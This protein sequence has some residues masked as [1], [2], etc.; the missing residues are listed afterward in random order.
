M[1]DT[2]S[3]DN[4]HATGEPVGEA[5]TDNIHA[6]SE[7][8]TTKNLITKDDGTGDATPD[9]IHATDEPVEFYLGRTHT[10]RDRPRRRGGGAVAAD[11]C[12]GPDA[13]GEGPRRPHGTPAA[14][15]ARHHTAQRGRR[16]PSGAS[17]YRSRHRLAEMERDKDEAI[18][19]AAATDRLGSLSSSSDAGR[20]GGDRGSRRLDDRAPPSTRG[21]PTGT[22]PSACRHGRDTDA[23]HA[24]ARQSLV[25]E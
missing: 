17:A 23:V 14:R 25:R 12:P 2:N 10:T 20:R 24:V 19:L 16:P 13:P 4:I 3:T 21:P 22:P 18:A 6:T 1:S 8:L 7:P 11:V 9:N 15:R 5:T